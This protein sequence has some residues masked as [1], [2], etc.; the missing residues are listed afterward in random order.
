MKRRDSPR[1]RKQGSKRETERRD[2]KHKNKERHYKR[3]GNK[4]KGWSTSTNYEKKRGT[5]RSKKIERI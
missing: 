3:D 5:P 1:P 2:R 4:R